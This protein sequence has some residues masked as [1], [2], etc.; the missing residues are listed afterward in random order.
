MT[1]QRTLFD[2]GY[3]RANPLAGHEDH[4][5]PGMKVWLTIKSQYPDRLVLMKMDAFYELFGPD[6]E[7]AAAA[8]DLTL[9]SRNA[10][11]DGSLRVAMCGF[12][13]YTLERYQAKLIEQGHALVVC[14]Q[15]EWLGGK[16]VGKPKVTPLP[17]E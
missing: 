3:G 9:V 14:E 2:G 13:V 11:R 17:L 5:L 7:V 8:A 10:T 12:P 4:I 15:E 6:A 1:T 16:P